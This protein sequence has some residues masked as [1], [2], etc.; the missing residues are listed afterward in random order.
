MKRDAVISECERYRY[1]LWRRWGDSQKQP[2]MWLML[3][4]STADA[5]I[6]D[7]T[8]RRCI[9]FT[10]A[11]GFDCMFVGNLFGIRSTDPSIL[12]TVSVAEA[13]GP[14]NDWHLTDMASQSAFVVCAWGAM[15]GVQ[16][17][18]GLVSPGG[19]WCLGTTK[20]GSPRHPLYVAGSQVRSPFPTEPK[21]G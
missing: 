8:I 15:G 12:S 2:V 7:P 18:R 14:E 17:P 9:G 20:H 3:N 1:R 5:S 19:F 11:W 10:T 13:E 21:H 4:P 16:P 6:D